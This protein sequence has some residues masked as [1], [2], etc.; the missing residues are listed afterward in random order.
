MAVLDKQRTDCLNKAATTIQR[1]ARGYL[2]R[3]NY[4]RSKAAI[5]TL[6]A[7]ARGLLARRSYAD[8]RRR[9][10]AVV[11]QTAW[12]R[13][14][15]REEYKH[16]QRLVVAVQ[17]LWRGKQA[18]VGYEAARRERAA[19]A[20]Q[21]GWRSHVAAA[22]FQRRRTEAREAGKLLEDKKALETKLKELEVT[23][24]LVQGQ[25]NGLR[26]EVKDAKAALAEAERRAAE[27]EAE[28]DAA[29]ATAGAAAAAEL[30]ALRRAGEEAEAKAAAASGELSAAREKL[31]GDK[32]ELTKKLGVAQD[33]IQRL[34]VEKA[35]LD[36]RFNGMKDEL[37]TRLQNACAQRDEA[38][39]QVMEL[40]AR[41]LKAVADL[42]QQQGDGARALAAAAAAA[43]GAAGAAPAAPGA[44]AAPAAAAA[45]GGAVDLAAFARMGRSAMQQL[46]AQGPGVARMMAEAAQ[47]VLGPQ[48][49]AAAAGGGAGGGAAGPEAAAAARAAAA[50]AGP[51]VAMLSGPEHVP[52]QPAIPGGRM[53]SAGGAQE[54]E[55]ERRTRELQA[56]QLALMQE[57]RRQEE[58]RLLSSLPAP[59]GFHKGRP[60]AALVVFRCCLQWRA[61]QAD[62]TSVFDRIIHVIGAQIERHQEDNPRLSYWLTNTTT[63]LFLLQRNIKPASSGSL[64]GRAAAAGRAA[65]SMLNNWLGRGASM[66]GG[67]ASI[68]G[69][70][71]GGFRLVEAKYPALL[72]KQQLDAF[73]QKVFPMLRDNVKKAITPLLAHCIHTP[74]GASSRTIGPGRRATGGDASAG[75]GAAAAGPAATAAAAAAAQGKAWGEILAVLDALLEDV[76]AA[77][78]PKPLVQALF[79]QLFAFVNVQLFNQLLLRRE[80]CSFSNGEYV[81]TGLAQVEGWIQERGPEWV[82]DSW[83]E[84]RFIRQAVTFLVV[85]N[86]PRKA[87]DDITRDLCPVLSIQQLY[88]ISTMYWDDKYNTETVS[89]EVLGRMKAAMVESSASSAASHSFLLDDDSTLPFS[90]ADIVGQMDDRDLYSALPIPDCLRA[91]GSGGGAEGGGGGSGGG[92]PAPGGAPGASFAFLEKEI[93]SGG[94][95]GAGDLAHRLDGFAAKYQQLDDRLDSLERALVSIYK[96]RPGAGGPAGGPAAA[97]LAGAAAAGVGLRGGPADA[98]VSGRGGAAAGGGAGGGDETVVAVAAAEG[99]AGGGGLEDGAKAGVEGE[100]VGAEVGGMHVG[101]IAFDI[102]KLQSSVVETLNSGHLEAIKTLR[103]SLM[104]HEW[105]LHGKRLALHR[106]VANFEHYCALQDLPITYEAVSRLYQDPTD[107]SCI[108]HRRLKIMARSMIEQTLDERYLEVY[109]QTTAAARELASMNMTSKLP[110]PVPGAG[111]VSGVAGVV[112]SLLRK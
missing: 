15:L 65:G 22:D 91:D 112:R 45:G 92:A 104:A 57:R 7:A 14:R 11:V 21:S 40:E 28:R 111:A 4:R 27:L 38:R 47:G 75:G 54:T 86:K 6:Q 108:E 95:A 31:A 109:K 70:G 3:L 53:P 79:R 41:L 106:G 87:L 56:K 37:I 24:E 30:D 46:A 26:A 61:F 32:S 35:D 98:A 2:G 16:A 96:R 39:A 29:A 9:R 10:A 68:H 12:R 80:C 43:A 59:M 82:G 74:R 103:E 42:Q 25:R 90:A 17:A 62:R 89:S 107:L 34:M 44:P 50:A 23:L 99:R 58:E 13:H 77:Y 73:V 55:L 72:F 84:L 83:D 20:L 100:V 67:E 81:K 63:L 8:L 64:K 48:A 66:G 52:G 49:A 18:R 1:F 36:K 33:Y 102:S 93:N 69:G 105:E 110:I 94:G 71:V 97:P 76:R 85:G 5:V 19:T 101:G 60:V 51:N 88:R 78:V